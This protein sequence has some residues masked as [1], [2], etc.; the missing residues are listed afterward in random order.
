MIERM[1]LSKFPKFKNH[2]P[3]I[4]KAYYWFREFISDP[5]WERRKSAIEMYLSSILREFEPFS[6]PISA[7][8]LLAVQKDQIAWYLYLVHTYLFEPHKYEFYQG[9]RVL[10]IFKR[11]GMDIDLVGGIKGLRA[12]VRN[13]CKKRT[14]EADAI[15][16]EV[17]TALLW[18]RGGWSVAVIEEG[19]AGKTPDFL[20]SKGLEQWQVECKRQQ[21]TSEYARTETR[22][23]QALITQ[24]S[25]LLLEFNVLL[26]VTFHVELVSLPDTY[27]LDMLADII[28]DTKSPGRIV[29]NKEVDIDLAFVDILAIQ[30]HLES[31]FVKAGSPKHVELIAN[32]KVDQ[33]A[34]T[35]G[36]V[37]NFFYVGEGAANN[38]YISE[39]NHAY[40][41]H[42]YCDAEQA[43]FAK[44]RDVRNYI[45][46]AIRQF[47]PDKD[48]II[49]IGM[50]TF[51]GPAVEKARM[52][53]INATM[54]KIDTTKNRLGWI[55]YHFFQSY[56]RSDM[57]WYFDETVSRASSFIIATP[58][59]E[60]T[61]LI[62]PEDLSPSEE[63]M[64]WDRELP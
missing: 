44:A 31:Y 27:L 39:M 25:R 8:T 40:G 12:K 62:Y 13:M 33:S 34:F 4:E 14:A 23:R 48:A 16:F 57:D 52:E 19:Q 58:P 59:I 21:K 30:R 36:F 29:S 53:K 17:L 45:H 38:L 1:P 55:Y 20:V 9:A 51:D 15:L 64:H 56:S 24:V 35:S 10:P 49:H 28:P 32:K 5:D 42:C 61:F 50:E 47:S 22:K 41:V 54:E 2:E 6:E 7:G 46:D 43:I 3:D 11:I 18:A 60:K 63:G 26:D 37:G